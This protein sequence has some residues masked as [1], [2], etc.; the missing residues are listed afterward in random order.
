MDRRYYLMRKNE[1]ITLMQF[2]DAGK[3][4]AYS[5]NITESAKELAAFGDA[6]R[7]EFSSVTGSG[8]DELKDLII[9]L[10]EV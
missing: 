1:V 6:P 3:L 10:T 4:T 5:R 8:T 9:K 2:D 7:V